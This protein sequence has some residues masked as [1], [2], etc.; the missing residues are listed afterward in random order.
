MGTWGDRYG[1]VTINK[2]LVYSNLLQEFERR[3]RKVILICTVCLSAFFGNWVGGIF[4]MSS[5]VLFLIN[6]W[7]SMNSR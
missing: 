3:T 5:H 6:E 4:Y 2:N 1:P 7:I